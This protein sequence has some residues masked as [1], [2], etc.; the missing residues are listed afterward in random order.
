[1]LGTSHDAKNRTASDDD[2]LR[3]PLCHQK[4]ITMR[5]YGLLRFSKRHVRVCKSDDAGKRGKK[6]Q[7]CQ[8]TELL[9]DKANDSKKMREGLSLHTNNHDAHN[10]SPKYKKMLLDKI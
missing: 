5:G 1:M 6:R 9:T 2:R 10:D 4:K 8:E 3:S 7:S